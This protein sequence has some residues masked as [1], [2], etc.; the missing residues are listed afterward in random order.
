MFRSFLSG[1]CELLT[2]PVC[3]RCRQP[4]PGR[5]QTRR[6]CLPC[7]EHLELT[8]I[9]LQGTEPL[10]WW[11]L[12]AYDS[13]FRRELLGL[14]KRPDPA[15]ISALAHSLA[16]TL[17]GA[18]CRDALLVAVPS[19]KRRAN[20]LPEQICAG[21]PLPVAPLLRRRHATLGQ[22]HLNRQLRERNQAGS[23]CLSADGERLAPQGLRARG[24]LPTR[25]RLPARAWRK[26]QVLLV[27]DILTTG[28]TAQAA[29]VALE[30]GGFQVAGLLCL[31]RTPARRRHAP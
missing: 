17:P 20:P 30:Q 12:G 14:R 3:P 11:S 31:A 13:A 25:G 19:W 15:V 27:D 28:A 5:E 16:A 1:C 22:H 26:R 7:L 10:P 9:G 8:D 21:L 23:F 4:L 6:L 24:D 29:A 2:I 18:L